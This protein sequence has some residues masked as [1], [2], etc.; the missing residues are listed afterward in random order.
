MAYPTL[1][2]A[3]VKVTWLLLLLAIL[4]KH[5]FTA[6]SL[7]IFISCLEFYI[8]YSPLHKENYRLALKTIKID[9]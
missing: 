3:L 5:S 4:C 9:V 7:D 8:R 2:G 1:K 6:A